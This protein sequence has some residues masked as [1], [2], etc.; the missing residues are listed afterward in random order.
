VLPG[1][2]GYR[3]FVSNW[4]EV[5]GADLRI[6]PEERIDLGDRRV[7]LGELPLRAQAS[8]VPITEK[9]AYVFTLKDGLVIRHEE[10][11]HHGEALKAVGLED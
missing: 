7:M 6:E 8:G 4:S 1:P 5:F 2:E 9:L 10:Y 3:E 11:F